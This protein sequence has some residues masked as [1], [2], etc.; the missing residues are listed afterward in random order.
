MSDLY[1]KFRS[2]NP[3]EEENQK[4]EQRC[5]KVCETKLLEGVTCKTTIASQAAF[6]RGKPPYRGQVPSAYGD[7]KDKYRCWTVLPTIKLGQRPA[8]LKSAEEINQIVES[9]EC[10]QCRRKVRQELQAD[11]VYSPDARFWIGVGA[12]SAGV[13]VSLMVAVTR[14][15]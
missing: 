14:R 1:Q 2:K 3:V 15:R 6:F 13:L 8:T 4:V 7:R 10:F 12:A 5:A 11:M 9:N